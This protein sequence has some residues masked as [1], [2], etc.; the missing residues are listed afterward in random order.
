MKMYV[1]MT[2]TAPDSRT[3]LRL[4]SIKSRMMPTS[5]GTRYEFRPGASAMRTSTPAVTETATVVM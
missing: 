5:M 3:P 1:G 2:K 4:T